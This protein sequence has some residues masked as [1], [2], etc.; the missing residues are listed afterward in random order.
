MTS[1]DITFAPQFAPLFS[2]GPFGYAHG[3]LW[4][5]II[6]YVAIFAALIYGLF[7]V[8]AYFAGAASATAFM[9]QKQLVKSSKRF[10]LVLAIAL[11]PNFIPYTFYPY[12]AESL[13]IVYAIIAQIW[14]LLA[15]I[16]LGPFAKSAWLTWRQERFLQNSKF[17]IMEIRIPREIERGPYAM[18]QVFQAVWQLSNGPG[19]FMESYIDGEVP[20]PMSFEI[21][22]FGGEIHF[23]ARIYGKIKHLLE[24]SFGALKRNK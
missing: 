15:L 1:V 19:H 20:R 12:I 13:K 10:A 18:D 4:A 22:S 24:G 14:W 3:Y 21:V 9:G 2:G 17:K 11:L 16:I 5:E 8:F 6:I 7:G 23:Y